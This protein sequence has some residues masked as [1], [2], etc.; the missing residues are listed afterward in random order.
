MCSILYSYN[1][2]GQRKEDGIK[3]IVRKRKDIYSAVLYLLK[4]NPR[5]SGLVQFEAM[6]FKCQLYMRILNDEG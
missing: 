1:R 5:R 3:K 6:L 4:K 2:V